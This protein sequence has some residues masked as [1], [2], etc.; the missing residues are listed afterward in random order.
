MVGSNDQSAIV[1]MEKLYKP[2]I[3]QSF[4][5]PECFSDLLKT[6][7]LND[8]ANDNHAVPFIVT[9]LTSAEL[10]KY[11]ANAFLALKISFANEMAG[12]CEKAGADIREVIKGIGLDKRIGQTFFKRWHWLGRQLLWQRRQCLN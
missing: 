12:L 9:D 4:A 5:A 10:I 8:N 7:L 2:L 1:T 3:E 6:D 11:A